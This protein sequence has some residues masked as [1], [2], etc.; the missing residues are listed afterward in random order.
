MADKGIC[1]IDEFDKMSEVDRTSIHEAMEQQTIS[2]AKAGIQ[3]TLNARCSVLAAAN[4]KYGRYDKSLDLRKNVEM[5]PPLMSRFDLFFVVVDEGDEGVDY[6]I[7]THIVNLHA[8]GDRALEAE[9]PIDII[10]K[11]IMA[12]R[13]VNPA[14]TTASAILLRDQYKL[15]RQTD[16]MHERNSYRI[17]VRQLESLIRLSEAIARLNFDQYVRQEYVLEACR[18]LKKSI[19]HVERHDVEVED[20]LYEAA[21]NEYRHQQAQI[22]KEKREKEKESGP[23]KT[24]ITFEEYDR[25][26]KWIAIFL[27]QNEGENGIKQQSIVDQYVEQ[28]LN[29]ITGTE[30]TVKMIETVNGVIQRLVGRDHILVVIEDNPD[31]SQRTLKVH[32][33]YVP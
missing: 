21:M 4:P 15:L 20:E 13:H 31:R 22:D 17:T 28:H 23:K 1:L 14:F 33:N 25:M 8:K 32:W 24:T 7:A 10:Q 5:S 12:A 18:L 6:A 30:D 16:S 26:A 27:R 19:I 11:Y 29:E 2:I 9:F 3:A